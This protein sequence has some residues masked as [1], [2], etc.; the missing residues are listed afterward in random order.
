MR[1]P[2]GG[3]LPPKFP[4][5]WQSE[6]TSLSSDSTAT[7]TNAYP[8]IIR[9][10]LRPVRTLVPP[11]FKGWQ[12]LC[13]VYEAGSRFSGSGRAELFSLRMVRGPL[14][15]PGSETCTRGRESPISSA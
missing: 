10:R 8:P 13:P 2:S 11:P 7:L 9:S 3:N 15:V 1:W 14:P 6:T 5:V 4:K 12:L